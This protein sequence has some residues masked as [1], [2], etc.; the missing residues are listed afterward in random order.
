MSVIV[1]AKSAKK[2]PEGIFDFP[3]IRTYF[4]LYG[5]SLAKTLDLTKG[6]PLEV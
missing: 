3:T 5:N 1:L 6:I 4:T 2:E